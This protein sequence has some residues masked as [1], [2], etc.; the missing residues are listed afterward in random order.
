MADKKLNI[1]VSTTG[2]SK[3]QKNLKGLSGSIKTLGKAA[4]ATGAAYFATRGLINGFSSALRL[5]GEQEQAE[6]KLATALGHTSRA[7]LNQASAFQKVS[8]FG[9]ETLIEM[10]A[11]AS[12]MGIAEDQI[13]STT[14]MAIGLSEAF[15][16]D[17][18]MSM[19]AA[20]AAVQGDTM[21]LSK[22]RI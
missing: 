3:S 6:K 14:E 5:A 11:L 8:Q 15:S 22:R 17:L 7:L 20:A 10:M 18:N 19:K 9:D 4:L 21:M 1:K 12:N 2:A 16:L 13:A